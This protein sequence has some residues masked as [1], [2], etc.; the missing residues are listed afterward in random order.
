MT[1]L[2]N[3][4]IIRETSFKN[5][6]AVSP[7]C[8]Y[9]AEDGFASDWHLVHLGSRA[10][11]GAGLVILEAT[12]VSPE[13]R[14]SPGDLGIW[15]DEQ[16]QP[17]RRITDFISAQGAIPGIQL[18]HAGRKASKTSPWQG[19]KQLLT[20][21]GGWD[22][23]CSSALPF[24]EEDRVPAE[25][26]TE[27][28]ESIKKAFKQAVR[29]SLDAGFRVIEIHAAHG[30]LIHQFLSPLCNKRTDNYGGSFENRIRFLMEIIYDIS[31]MLSGDNPLFVRISATDWHENG[32][33][34]E[35]SVRLGKELKEAGVDLV[36]CSSGGII[37]GLII[38]T[39]PAYQVELAA[40]IRREAGI[41]TAAVGIITN[42]SLASEILSSG[43]ADLVLMGRELLRNPY[44]PLQ[45]AKEVGADITWPVQYQRARR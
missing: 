39:G 2:F 45:A 17:L 32:W 19:D 4:L 9:S 42:A 44:F 24:S 37:P 27:D 28:I 38:P 8:Q 10:V 7:M 40:R 22:T 29:R 13:G 33:S 6:I 18:G 20:E 12:A 15:K 34:I 1:G 41:M 31:P 36:D 30:Y 25:M 5:R 3:E 21:D 16:V 26:T 11:G 23:L 14:I 35:D 43:S